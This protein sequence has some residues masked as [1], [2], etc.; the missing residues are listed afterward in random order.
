MWDCLCHM[1]APISYLHTHCSPGAIQEKEH[2]DPEDNILHFEHVFNAR[3]VDSLNVANIPMSPRDID[4]ADPNL[5]SGKVV[6]ISMVADKITVE[7]AEVTL[8]KP[9]PE[10]VVATSF[11]EVRAGQATAWRGHGIYG[12]MPGPSRN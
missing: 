7:D 5:G 1:V 3:L 10:P 4:L 12:L 9:K 2:G 6:R 11:A 8:G